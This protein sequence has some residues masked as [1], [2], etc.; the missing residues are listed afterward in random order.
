MAQDELKRLEKQNEE[1]TQEV[2]QLVQSLDERRA[3]LAEFETKFRV[4]YSSYL[5][6]QRKFF[7]L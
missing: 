4:N 3:L 7:S 5:N 1:Y 6:I 2:Q